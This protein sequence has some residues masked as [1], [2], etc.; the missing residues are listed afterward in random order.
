MTA[1]P[2]P[3]GHQGARSLLIAETHPPLTHPAGWLRRWRGEAQRQKDLGRGS[4]SRVSRSGRDFQPHG[5]SC[6]PLCAQRRARGNG[7]VQGH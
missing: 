4:H 6:S 3:T 2:L 1:R 5:R 7:L